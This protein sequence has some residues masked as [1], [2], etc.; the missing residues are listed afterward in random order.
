MRTCRSGLPPATQAA[1]AWVR[2]AEQPEVTRPHS[3]PVSVGQSRA[4]RLRQLVE[5]DVVLGGRVHGRAHLGQH[6]GSAQDRVRAPRVDERTH[7]DRLV[8]VRADAQAHARGRRHRGRRRGRGRLADEE[9]G[10]GREH[11]PEV[12]PY[13]TARG[14]R[15]LHSSWVL[16]LGS[17]VG[18]RGLYRSA[19]GKGR[20]RGDGRW[21]GRRKA[22]GAHRIRGGGAEGD[23]SRPRRVGQGQ[24]LP[25]ARVSHSGPGQPDGARPL[26]ERPRHADPWHRGRRAVRA[27]PALP[28]ADRRLL[29]EGRGRQGGGAARGPG[30]RPRRLPLRPVGGSLRRAHA[31]HGRAAGAGPADRAARRPA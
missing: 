17:L 15:F 7:A 13:G 18:M 11:R 22:R 25:D 30:G 24:Q 16:L 8:D 20:P 9:L 23:R 10:E 14:E 2:A 21:R 6:R 26:R 29:P 4:D 1:V 3:A 31:A 27:A 28:A 12:R 5:V 19:A